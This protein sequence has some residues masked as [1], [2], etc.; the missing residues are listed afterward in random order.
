MREELNKSWDAL[1]Q[2]LLGWM[3]AIVENLPNLAL[4][5]IVMII[6]Y[7]SAKYVSKL[8]LKLV[9][10]RVRQKSV[11]NIIAR[12]TTVFVVFV[13][14]FLALGIL[15]LSQTLTSLITGAGVLGL[16]IGLALQGTLSNTISGIVI[17]FRDK[18]QIGNW[19]ETNDF[20]GEIIDIN[21]KNFTLKESD[22]NMVIIPNKTILE[23]PMK[24]YSLTPYIRVD[25]S[26]GV[27]YS[28]D[29]EFVEKLT[30]ETLEKTFE[31]IDD[32][33]PV[34]FFFTE[35]GDS[36]INFKCR[37]WIEGTRNVHK[38]NATNKAIIAIKKAFDAEGINIPFPIRT[39]QF[40]NKLGLEKNGND[41]EDLTSKP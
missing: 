15:N 18:I 11:G 9:G 8:M 12:L 38:L 35:F 30:K 16:V 23:T 19:V 41:I 40:D 1:I 3:N 36:S 34:E 6:A 21:L 27:H 39:L 31:K 32:M 37:F 25:L 2:K 33:K 5:I 14:L 28:S 17:S 26:C 13:G 22:N 20:A 7:F 4:A 10:S 29:L 24:N